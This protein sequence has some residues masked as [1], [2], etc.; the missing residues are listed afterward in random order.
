MHQNKYI[1]WVIAIMIIAQLSFCNSKKEDNKTEEIKKSGSI[2]L[3]SSN[4][5]HGF[6]I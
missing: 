1:I 5:R 6:S 2:Q 4:N 3:F